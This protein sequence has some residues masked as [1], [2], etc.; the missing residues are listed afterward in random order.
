MGRVLLLTSFALGIFG[1]GIGVG[2]Y[3]CAPW[4]VLA[5]GFRAA[6]LP[7][8]M[9]EQS[10][11]EA[12]ADLFGRSKVPAEIV[13]LGDSLTE[14]GIWAELLE[15]LS[16]VNRGIGGDGTTGVLKRLSEVLGR[17]PR[18]LCL[19][20][21]SNDLQTKVPTERVIENIRGITATASQA[22]SL[23]ILQSVPFVVAGYRPGINRC[24]EEAQ[25]QAARSPPTRRKCASDLNAIL[26]DGEAPCISTLERQSSVIHN[27]HDF[28]AF[29]ALCCASL[30]STRSSRRSHRWSL[31]P[32]QR[33]FITQLVGNIG[34]HTPQNV[35]RG[36]TSVNRF[37][38]GITRRQHVPLRT[39]V[40]IQRTA[41]STRRVGMG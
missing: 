13:M 36:T 25:R 30:R 23:V 16:I 12:K 29:S 33:A 5:A 26:A 41:S 1:Y 27:R 14:M 11:Q 24:V 8:A 19:D 18:V 15:G 37:V 4:H 9:I 10:Y 32:L 20:I 39:H 34:Q 31:V 21:G 35:D 38:I 22:G 17:N 40:E 28:Y 6:R 3:Q 7:S 2:H